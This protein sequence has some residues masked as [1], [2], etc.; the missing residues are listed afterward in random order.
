MNSVSVARKCDN[1]VQLPKQRNA[2]VRESGA[3]SYLDAGGDMLSQKERDGNFFLIGRY[4]T[5]FHLKGYPASQRPERTGLN[6][7]HWM[8]LELQD[9]LLAENEK[10]DD[11]KVGRWIGY[12]QCTLTENR[13]ID[14]V[15]EADISRPYFGR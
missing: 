7:A 3:M 1:T 14:P 6:H 13:W 9:Q 12:I 15:V 8:L 11:G 10:F 2:V 5:M 4:L